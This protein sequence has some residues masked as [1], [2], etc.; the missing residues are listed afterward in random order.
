MLAPLPVAVQAQEKTH[1]QF[2]GFYTDLGFGYRG[3][4]TSISSV[5]TLNGRVIPSSINSSGSSHQVAVLT[6]GYNFNIAQNYYLGIG[7]N[8]SP[9]NGLVQQLQVQALN[10][11]ATVS[12][13][14][15]LYN[16]GFFLSPGF[17]T[18]DGLFYLKA[19]KQTQVVNSNTGPNLSSYLLGLGYKQFVYDAIYLFG[20][21]NYSSY[22]PQTTTRTIISSGRTIN[23]SITTS[24]QTARLLLGLGYQF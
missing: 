11:T 14:S 2:E 20:E 5:L 12:S 3:I 17:Q 22:D 1:S 4:N 16:Y 15:P 8:I 21:A 9:S 7:A 10:Q 23:A 6:T 24:S 13:G 19:G 18:E